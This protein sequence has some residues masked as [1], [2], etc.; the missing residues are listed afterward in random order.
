VEFGS[1]E[2]PFFDTKITKVGKEWKRMRGIVQVILLPWNL[3]VWKD[4]FN[5]FSLAL[6]IFVPSVDNS[7]LFL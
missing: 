7:S 1:L 2:G 5:D 6:V 4:S 3:G